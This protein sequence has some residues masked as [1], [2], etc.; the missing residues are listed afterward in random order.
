M[1]IIS[2]PDAPPALGHY[3]QA[4]IH[5]N[6][7]YVSGQLPLNPQQPDA[8]LGTIETQTRQTLN[9]IDAILKAAHSDR[10]KVLKVTIFMTDLN[11]WPQINTTYAE[12]FGNHKPARAAVPIVTLPKG[13]LLEIEVIAAI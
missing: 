10:S 8:P 5:N 3:S 1:Q 7:I 12:F 11:D 9:N 2:T 13:C 4:I 6:L